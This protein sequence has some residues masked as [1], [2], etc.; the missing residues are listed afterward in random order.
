MIEEEEEKG[1]NIIYPTSIKS[2]IMIKEKLNQILRK[3]IWNIPYQ[4]LQKT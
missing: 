1:D 3:W 4:I 2:K